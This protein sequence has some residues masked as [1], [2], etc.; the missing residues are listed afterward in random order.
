MPKQILAK[1]GGDI[2]LRETLACLEDD[3]ITDV[4]MSIESM[5]EHSIFLFMKA[6]TRYARKYPIEL[7]PYQLKFIHDIVSS[8]LGGKG[9]EIV[10]LFSRQSGKTESIASSAYILAATAHLTARFADGIRI[11][12]FGPKKEQSDIAFERILNFFDDKFCQDVLGVTIV[13]RN[14]TT[15]KLSN[16]SVIKSLTASKNA[17]IEGETMDLVF[18]EEAQDVSDIRLQK[19]IFPMLSSTEGTRVLT[20]TPTPEGIGYFFYASTKK[21]Q[22]VHINPWRIAAAYSTKYYNY[23]MRELKKHGPKSDWFLTQYECEWLMATKKF[24]TMEKL[25]KCSSGR[26]ILTTTDPVFIGIDPA[27]LQDP[28]VI[29][30]AD[31]N[32]NIINFMELEGEDYNVQLTIFEAVINQYPN[33]SVG[34]DTLGPGEVLYDML[35]QKFPGRVFRYPFATQQKSDMF[36]AF[37]SAV[38]NGVFKYFNDECPEKFRFEEQ[39]IELDA[40]WNGPILVVRAPSGRNKHDD[41]PCATA[42]AFTMAD[43]GTRHQTFEFSVGKRSSSGMHRNI[44][45]GRSRYKRRF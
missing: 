27:K 4:D 10:G 2:S 44:N 26:R 13:T 23:V 29:A 43:E 33:S 9:R 3:N 19:S 8:T 7:R 35:C 6:S 38:D 25:H 30:V 22:H 36:K 14:A 45:Q 20:G 31:V 32:K 12:I 16:K 17:T 11:G 1:P 15:L 42:I 5:T 40:K 21:S 24:T 39:M 37:K 34:I 28:T 41:Y 18:I